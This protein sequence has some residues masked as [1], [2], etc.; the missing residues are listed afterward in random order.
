MMN[1]LILI[2]FSIFINKCYFTTELISVKK[3]ML[4]KVITGKN[5]EWY[6]KTY[7][8]LSMGLNLKNQFVLVVMIC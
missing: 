4:L 3:V 1:S 6:F 7:G 2:K 8:V 5:T